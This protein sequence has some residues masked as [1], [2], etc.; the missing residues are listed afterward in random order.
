MATFQAIKPVSFDTISFSSLLNAG[1][2][3]PWPITSEKGFQVFEDDTGTSYL[4]VAGLNQINYDSSGFPASGV[5]IY[6]AYMARV[7][8]GSPEWQLNYFGGS[9]TDFMAQ[10]K[11]GNG[12]GALA[13]LLQGDDEISLVAGGLARGFAGDDLI[14]DGWSSSD[15]LFGG[16]GADTLD[17]SGG[18]DVLDGGEGD[19]RLRGGDDNDTLAGNAG[20]DYIHGESGNDSMMGGLG[21]DELR[22]GQ[23][24]DVVRGGAGQDFLRGAADEDVL[25]GGLGNDTLFG[26]QHDDTLFGGGGDD[27]LDG[28]AHR[29]RLTG[30]V[31]A[32]SFVFGN[33]PD[34]FNVD[35]ITDFEVGVD[36]IVLD[37]FIP[38]Q[39]SVLDQY[40]FESLA[41]LPNGTLP[42]GNFA[43]SGSAQGEDD[44]ILYDTTTHVLSYDADGSGSEAATP[45]AILENGAD[46]SATDIL[47]V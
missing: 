23:D 35:T 40:I 29:D 4:V 28:K 18:A 38:G 3:A 31:G 41:G 13:T 14:L 10:V 19:D 15:T 32:D 11:A 46:I 16:G 6:P 2:Y 20:N 27:H 7:A 8:G 25:R 43:A 21:N 45:I 39:F 34:G 22:G 5:F 30:G 42:A 17:A 1:A 9:V 44:Y 12:L 26:G 47:L 24:N 36:K 33:V 37:V